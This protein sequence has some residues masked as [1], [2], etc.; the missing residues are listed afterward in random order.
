MK[1]TNL[2]FVLIA[3]LAIISCSESKK[4]IDKTDLQK[5]LQISYGKRPEIS[6][7]EFAKVS[8]TKEDAAVIQKIILNDTKNRLLKTLGNEWKNQLVE[9]NGYQM[10]LKYKIFNSKPKNGR[11]LFISLHG[12][13]GTTKEVNDQQWENQIRLYS[14]P[15]G[16]YV[17]PRSPTN[18]WNMW[19]QGHV[20]AL[21]DKII[22]AAII[23]EDVD[24]N[25][26]YVMGYSA[27]GDGTYQI[28]P[29]LADRWAA[30]AMMA[31][32]P[33]DASPV[34]LL[35][36]PFD[37]WVG[38]L[39]KAYD[40]NMFVPIWGQ[41]L[42]SLQ[43][44]N[45]NKYIHETHVVKGKGHWMERVDSVSVSWMYKFTRNPYPK[46]VAWIQDDVPQPQLYWIS[47][48][49]NEQIKRNTITASINK[50]VITIENA[51]IKEVTFWLNDKMIDLD[52][53]VKIIN[54]D[55][56]IFNDVVHRTVEAI[57]LNAN[58]RYDPAKLFTAK[59]NVK[60]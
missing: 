54:K 38:E 28:A 23:C 44:N 8:L 21:F 29:R 52:K 31:G 18:T 46:K 60:L 13:G 33:G 15:E 48:P 39:D 20:D 26:V 55:K 56:V 24:P 41:M 50:N 19:H 4:D 35:N 22:Q 37:L 10:A 34:N 59:V 57:Y 17:A 3:V 30:A 45:P 27:G 5:W 49:K 42:D 6:N 40:R 9:A 51:N 43:S 58:N 36:L 12:G 14:P 7:Q 25:R 53:P 2:F 11:S 47:M 16:V 32:H 1:I